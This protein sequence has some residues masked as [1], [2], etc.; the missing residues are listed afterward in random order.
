[1]QWYH[2]GF[3]LA[4][5]ATSDPELVLESGMWLGRLWRLLAGVC[6]GLQ[7]PAAMDLLAVVEEY[8]KG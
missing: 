6:G 1:M 4:G 8:G 3:D 7:D 2:L 5:L